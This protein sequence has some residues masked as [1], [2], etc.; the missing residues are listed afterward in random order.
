M[1]QVVDRVR[2]GL[3]VPLQGPAGI[4]GPSC[5]AVAATAVRTINDTG[6]LGRE[7]T[8]GEVVWTGLVRQVYGVT[9]TPPD[10]YNAP[11]EPVQADLTNTDQAVSLC[12]VPKMATLRVL[13]F[14]DARRT[15]DPVGQAP[16]SQELAEELAQWQSLGAASWEMF[17]F[18]DE[19]EPS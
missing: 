1:G 2:V 13:A 18:D 6:I 17:S 19:G 8:I 4:F 9:A 11:P 12:M 15:C 5:E 3:I 16:M 10:G 7:L 14:Y